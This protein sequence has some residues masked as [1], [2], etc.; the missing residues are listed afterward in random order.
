MATHQKAMDTQ[1]I[2]IAQ[3]VSHLSRPQGHL[4]GQV[5]TNP[6]GHV[7]AI[8]TVRVGFEE[9]PVIVLQEIVS[10][11]VSVGAERQQKKGRSIPIEMESPEPSIH[12]YQPRVSYPQ[13]LVWTNLLQLE[14]KYAR[15]LDVLKRIYADTPFLETLKKAPACLQFVRDFLSKKGESEGGPVM[16]IGRMC[17]SFLQSHVKL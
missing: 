13:R 14:S 11:P 6:R 16:P 10:A 3:Q 8:S 9:S 17:S 15:F 1:I 5:E 4:S 12:P 2:Q 7:N